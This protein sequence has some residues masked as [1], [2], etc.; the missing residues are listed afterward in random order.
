MFYDFLCSHNYPDNDSA[1]AGAISSDPTNTTKHKRE[2]RGKRVPTKITIENYQNKSNDGIVKDYEGILPTS[3][4]EQTPLEDQKME[5]MEEVNFF[6]G[7]PFVE[8]TKGIIHLYK[9]NERT[10]IMEGLSRTL[11]LLAVPATLSCHDIINFVA[12]CHSVLQCIRII[13]DGSPNQFMVLLE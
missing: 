1:G 2:N 4:R 3:S 7:N 9:N 11:C 8:V 12:P 6:S 13:R 10:E 5:F